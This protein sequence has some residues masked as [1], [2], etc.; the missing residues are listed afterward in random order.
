MTA[1]ISI[2]TLCLFNSEWIQEDW[3]G[4]PGHLRLDTNS[5]FLYS[6]N[7]D[8][9]SDDTLKIGDWGWQYVNFITILT[10]TND[11]KHI[12]GDLYIVGKD[13]NNRELIVI[14]KNNGSWYPTEMPEG[15][16]SIGDVVEYKGNIFASFNFEDS[17]GIYFL[18]GDNDTSKVWKIAQI[19]DKA[20]RLTSLCNIDDSLLMVAGTENGTGVLYQSENPFN[21]FQKLNIS[22]GTISP[23]DKISYSDLRDELAALTMDNNVY[24]LQL[25]SPELQWVDTKIPDDVKS[26][27]DI[28]YLNNHIFAVGQ[29]TDNSGSVWKYPG[30][31]SEWK[32]VFNNIYFEEFICIDYFSADTGIYVSGNHR[33]YENTAIY[34]SLD[35][36]ESWVE[37]GAFRDIYKPDIAAIASDSQQLFAISSA[38]M[39]FQRWEVGKP[40]LFAQLISSIYD[41]G[42]S[43]TYDYVKVDAKNF[44]ES[45]GITLLVASLNKE[46]PSIV[47]WSSITPLDLSKG[48]SFDLKEY[49]GVT[50]GDRY[51]MYLL[52]F[53]DFSGLLPS[54]QLNKITIGYHSIKEEFFVVSHEPENQEEDVSISSPIYVTFS[55]GVDPTTLEEG[56]RVFSLKNGKRIQGSFDVDSNFVT[57]NPD[58]NFVYNDTISVELST[59]IRSTEGD[60]LIDDYS[61]IFYTESEPMEENSITSVFLNK[62]GK[63]FYGDTIEV[64]VEVYAPSSSVTGG[65]MKIEEISEIFDAVTSHPP[66]HT[67][68]GDIPVDSTLAI[69]SHLLY[70]EVYLENGEVLDTIVTVVIERPSLFDINVKIISFSGFSGDTIWMEFTVVDSIEGKRGIKE[71]YYKLIQNEKVCDSLYFPCKGEPKINLSFPIKG[72]KGGEATMQFDCHS[73]LGE[74]TSIE[75]PF[76]IK[77]PPTPISELVVYP[78]PCKNDELSMKFNV[79]VNGRFSFKI[80]TSDGIEVYTYPEEEVKSGET[81]ILDRKVDISDLPSG[82]YFLVFKYETYNQQVRFYKKRVSIVK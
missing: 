39:L 55:R 38:N 26:I 21:G 7:M 59:S 82:V 5:V 48:D 34:R 14:R 53:I 46:D 15:L 75:I 44:S 60:R 8:Y 74:K 22:T 79:R 33:D 45:R 62:E 72:A 65:V 6:L 16:L 58:S 10:S 42:E 73:T 20:D 61:F 18:T 54:P 70:I 81:V 49:N 68:D 52:T 50:P 1:F 25:S 9:F 71:I 47:D 37:Y 63:Y 11:M 77:E 41:T 40:F 12:K 30:E 64:S 3:R 66:F 32:K 29:D 80:L 43:S 51:L 27:S 24:T 78:N 36:G 2:L 69:G 35:D 67:L 13:E 57:F 76:T 23:I 28:L 31:E 56:F 4:G 17:C 19:L